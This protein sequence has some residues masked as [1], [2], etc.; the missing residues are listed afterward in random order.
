M[1][2][3]KKIMYFAAALLLLTGCRGSQEARE[4]APAEVSTITGTIELPQEPN[5]IIAPAGWQTTAKG[6]KFNMQWE[7]GDEIY[8]YKGSEKQL[9]TLKSIDENTSVAI[10]QGVALTDMSKY[11]VAYGYDPTSTAKTFTVPY[12]KD[13]YR[14]FADGTGTNY[15][16]TI[17]Q[18][19][20]VIGLKLKGTDAL[21][22]IEV[23][24]LN[25]SEETLATYTMEFSDALAL[26]EEDITNVYFPIQAKEDVISMAIRFYKMEEEEEVLIMTKTT[27]NLTK[28]EAGK[29][30][31]FKALTVAPTKKKVNG[32]EAVQLWENGPYW[33][34]CNV[35]AK[36]P[37]GYGDYFAWGET[38]TKTD[39]SWSTYFDLH[40]GNFAKYNNGGK[41]VLESID[42]A[43]R[44]NWGGTWRMPTMAEFDELIKNCAWEWCNGDTKKYNNTTVKGYIVKSKAPDNTNSIFLPAAGYFDGT[45][46]KNRG[47]NG[48]YWSASLSADN[49]Y[50]N[51]AYKLTFNN[52]WYQKQ[53]ELRFY[54]EFVRP[55]CQ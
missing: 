54:G 11:D 13:N 37:E 35:G 55:V 9:L 27:T 16:F 2:V 23:A 36:S 10:F 48:L 40:D 34:T 28:V 26:D 49:E 39:Y 22:K 50:T 51:F 33:A 7:N 52:S 6:V 43:A 4:N 38:I 45:E 14:P 30:T 25:S 42:D 47:S 21:T 24:L 17:N 1:K 3:M 8:I 19:G 15:N 53:V 32:H 29:V 44:A 20:P 31:T 18:F 41:T 12:V 5:K 46:H